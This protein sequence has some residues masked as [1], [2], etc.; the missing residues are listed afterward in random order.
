MPPATSMKTPV[1]KGQDEQRQS[2][3][4]DLWATTIRNRAAFTEHECMV[5]LLSGRPSFFN[6][7]LLMTTAVEPHT[8]NRRP[9][10]HKAT[11]QDTVRHIF[12]RAP[13]RTV[14]QRFCKGIGQKSATVPYHCSFCPI[15]FNAFST[16]QGPYLPCFQRWVWLGH[17]SLSHTPGISPRFYLGLPWIHSHE[18]CRGSG[19]WGE[20]WQS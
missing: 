4:G 15:T 6:Q 8:I 16:R 19:V 20:R 12:H 18:N 2:R 3:G 5:C 13:T 17:C 1:R 11:A 14:K 10:R 9:R 7:L